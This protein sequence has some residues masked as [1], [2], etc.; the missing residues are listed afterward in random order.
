ML[1]VKSLADGSC[2]FHSIAYQMN[3][4]AEGLRKLCSEAVIKNQEQDYNGLQLK[5]WIYYETSLSVE[6][7]SKRLLGRQWGGFLEMKII[8]DVF[9]RPI[10]VYQKEQ[11]QIATLI[12]AIDVPTNKD[13]KRR[14]ASPFYLLYSGRSHYDSLIPDNVC[15]VR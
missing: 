7:Y 8:S 13:R 2:F 5:D 14:N 3:G 10:A 1:I 9:Q 12:A 6:Q 11:G 15:S 4:T